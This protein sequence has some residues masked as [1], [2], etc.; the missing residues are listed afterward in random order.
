ML[1]ENQIQV[2]TKFVWYTTEIIQI[3]SIADIDLWQFSFQN[4]ILHRQFCNL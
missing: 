1:Q 2:V 4:L 3:I